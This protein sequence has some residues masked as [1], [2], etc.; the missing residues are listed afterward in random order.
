[1]DTF[2]KFK[3]FAKD[4]FNIDIERSDTDG[5]PVEEIFKERKCDDCVHFMRTVKVSEN[6]CLE[7]NPIG[8][9]S[10]DPNGNTI[11]GFKLHEE[12]D[13]ACPAYKEYKGV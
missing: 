2:E 8:T 1:M 10:T 5:I 12:K 9:C 6:E 13:E 7:S 4:E 3:Q 11:R